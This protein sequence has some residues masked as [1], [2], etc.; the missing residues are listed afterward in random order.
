MACKENTV[1]GGEGNGGYFTFSNK[2]DFFLETLL[3]YVIS[4]SLIFS[5][6]HYFSL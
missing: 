1:S 5:L 4:C 2:R 6:L 3:V